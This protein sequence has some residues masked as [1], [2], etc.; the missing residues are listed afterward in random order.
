MSHFHSSIEPLFAE[1]R[2]KMKTWL[3]DLNLQSHD[4][5]SLLS[6]LERF[7]EICSKHKLIL[8]AKKCTL[9]KKEIK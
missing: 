1:L 7:F 5:I 8:S 2:A 4:E 9:F 3:D 6:L